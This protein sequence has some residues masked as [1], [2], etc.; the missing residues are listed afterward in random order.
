MRG[1]F[2][3]SSCAFKRGEPGLS[4]G[5]VGCRRSDVN[6]SRDVFVSSTVQ[7][8]NVS[9]NKINGELR[10]TISRVIKH[11]NHG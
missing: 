11:F 8:D 1:K 10:R 4:Q 5:R 3:P 9:L 7:Q 2:L 6:R